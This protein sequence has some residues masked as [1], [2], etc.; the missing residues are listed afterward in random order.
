MALLYGKRGVGDEMDISH[1]CSMSDCERPAVTSIEL[2]PVCLLH[3]MTKC[4]SRLGVLSKKLQSRPLDQIEWETED[5]FT[6]ECFE[7]GTN[8]LRCLPDLN[9]S[10]RA[11]V[12]EI[13]FWATQLRRQLPPNR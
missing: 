6:T 13:I 10:D 8:I 5:R 1:Q 7:Q 9:I 2:N 11:R 3:F 12:F 4:K